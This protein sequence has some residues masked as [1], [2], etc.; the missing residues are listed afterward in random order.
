MGSDKSAENTPN[1]LKFICPNPKVWDFDEE[2]LHW[3][4]VVRGLNKRVSFLLQ[5]VIGL[6]LPTCFIECSEITSN[7]S[8]D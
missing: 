1:V 2:R 4:S 3:A 8:D 5:F 6:K 7:I